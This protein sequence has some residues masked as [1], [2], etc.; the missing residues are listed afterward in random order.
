MFDKLSTKN[1]KGGV[2]VNTIDDESGSDIEER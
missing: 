2:N 1:I